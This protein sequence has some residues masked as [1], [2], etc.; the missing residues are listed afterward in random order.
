MGGGVA[1]SV[2][3]MYDFSNPVSSR[4]K[5]ISCENLH[6]S[7]NFVQSSSKFQTSLRHYISPTFVAGLNRSWEEGKLCTKKC[8]KNC[9]QSPKMQISSFWGGDNLLGHLDRGTSLGEPLKPL[10]SVVDEN[11]VLVRLAGVII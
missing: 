3:K 5:I 4:V 7:K 10:E 11:P 8:A 6:Q 9:R 1:F 2:F